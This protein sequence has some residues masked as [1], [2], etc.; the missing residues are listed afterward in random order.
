MLLNVTYK[1]SA[2]KSSIILEVS[3][4]KQTDEKIP[5]VKTFCEPAVIEDNYKNRIE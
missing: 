2:S 5:F 3:R 1:L 4:N